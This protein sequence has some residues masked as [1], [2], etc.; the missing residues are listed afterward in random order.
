[1]QM[2]PALKP[3]GSFFLT[4]TST[5]GLP[6]IAH[7]KKSML[8]SAVYENSLEDVPLDRIRVLELIDNRIAVAAAQPREQQASVRI[9]RWIERVSETRQH[10]LV[11]LQAA[12]AFVNS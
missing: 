10:V 11:A 1:M 8:V 7:D 4:C 3:L 12:L 2:S 9:G 6:R 5:V